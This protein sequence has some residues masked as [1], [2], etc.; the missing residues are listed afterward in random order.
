MDD[1][2]LKY[3][4]DSRLTKFEDRVKSQ[5][6]WYQEELKRFT[7][8]NKAIAS[9]QYAIKPGDIESDDEV[10]QDQ[11]A[12]ELQKINELEKKLNS[13]DN[14]N[15][16][17]RNMIQRLEMELEDMKAQMNE[18]S[19]APPPLA[20]TTAAPLVDE[21]KGKPPINSP[22]QSQN[23]YHHHHHHHHHYHD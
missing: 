16:D 20:V 21:L 2:D 19:N 6:E 15:K 12:Y 11:R 1:A 3:D 10:N 8:A 14:S 5:L 13:K 17:L 18:K 7:D 9:N 22:T 4:I 23:N